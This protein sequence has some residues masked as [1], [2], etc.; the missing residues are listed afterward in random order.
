MESDEERLDHCLEQLRTSPGDAVTGELL[1]T[2]VPALLRHAECAAWLIADIAYSDAGAEFTAEETLLTALL[3]EA[4]R[5]REDGK[6][7]GHRA[8]AEASAMLANLD[9]D[10]TSR[11]AAIVITRVYHRTG[12][13]VPPALEALQGNRPAT[14]EGIMDMAELT[15]G[16]AEALQ[17]MRAESGDDAFAIYDALAENIAGMPEGG[18]EALMQEIAQWTDPFWAGV[19][20]YALLDPRPALRRGAAAGLRDRAK[21]SVLATTLARRVGQVR[22]LMPD[23]PSRA[24]VEAA[25]AVDRKHRRG[26]PTPEPRVDLAH[27]QV[28]VPDGASAQ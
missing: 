7:A 23:E 20:L 9:A 17:S 18:C 5:A 3:D 12:V 27:A 6:S 1:A 26:W 21:D 13:S 19:V 24:V 10:R 16:L 15:G 11:D 22:V 4:R 14:P 28:S 25:L 2:E 8:L